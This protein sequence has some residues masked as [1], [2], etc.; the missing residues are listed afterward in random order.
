MVDARNVDLN[1]AECLVRKS[2]IGHDVVTNVCTGKVM[3]VP[4]QAGD[5]ASMGAIIF[6]AALLVMGLVGIG[7]VIFNLVRN[8]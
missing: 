5:W 1:L 7:Y 3:E 4:W 6:C 2:A 8:H